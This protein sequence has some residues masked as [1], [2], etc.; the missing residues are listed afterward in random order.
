MTSFGEILKYLWQFFRVQSK[1]GKGNFEHNFGKFVMLLGKF[2]LLKR[3]K[4]WKKY[5]SIWSHCQ[6]V[7]AKNRYSTEIFQCLSVLNLSRRWR[8]QQQP[9]SMIACFNAR[10]FQPIWFSCV[11][12]AYLSCKRWSKLIDKKLEEIKL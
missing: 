7:R 5:L 3:A 8:Q 4:Y 1:L 9:W 11:L 2:S 6:Q 12:N 10:R